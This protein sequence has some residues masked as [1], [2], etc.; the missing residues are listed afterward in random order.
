MTLTQRQISTRQWLTKT[1]VG[2]ICTCPF[3]GGQVVGVYQ[4]QLIPAKYCYHFEG[5][6]QGHNDYRETFQEPAALFRGPSEELK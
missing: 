1:E 5:F 6:A 4:G 2:E 3:C